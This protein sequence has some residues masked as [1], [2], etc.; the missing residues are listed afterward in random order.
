MQSHPS[1]GL[2][3]NADDP[4]A[5]RPTEALS[6]SERAAHDFVDVFSPEQLVV[7]HDVT[8]APCRHLRV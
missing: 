3:S 7:I 2:S 4:R 1:P 5:E 6:S 8:T